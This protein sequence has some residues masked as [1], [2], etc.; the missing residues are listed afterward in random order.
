MM[1]RADGSSDSWNRFSEYRRIPQSS[2]ASV[3]GSVWDPAPFGPRLFALSGRCPLI[4]HTV[5]MSL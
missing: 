1:V 4:L 3:S 5:I 2:V